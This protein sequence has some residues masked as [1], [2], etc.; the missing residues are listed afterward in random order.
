MHAMRKKRFNYLEQSATGVCSP[1]RQSAKYD[2][3]VSMA[4]FEIQL[5]VMQLIIC[6]PTYSNRIGC[7]SYLQTCICYS[8]QF[9][10]N[11]GE[12]SNQLLELWLTA[13]RQ[14]GR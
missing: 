3:K 11:G 5:I 10:I 9:L 4:S 7:I 12:S 14:V 6:Y 13:G 8:F 2:K 1:N